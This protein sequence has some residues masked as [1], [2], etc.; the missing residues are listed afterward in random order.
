MAWIAKAE[1]IASSKTVV[2]GQ[3]NM[4]WRRQYVFARPNCPSA[5]ISARI[6]A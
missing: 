6:T 3:L 2:E 4:D 1:S 5:A